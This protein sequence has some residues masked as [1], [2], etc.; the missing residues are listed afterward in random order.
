MGVRLKGKVI[1]KNSWSDKV[2]IQP[3]YFYIIIIILILDGQRVTEKELFSDV[4]PHF[5]DGHKKVNVCSFHQDR[6]TQAAIIHCQLFFPFFTLLKM[7]FVCVP[8]G[9]IA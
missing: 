4:L 3:K 5:C 7:C 9:N 2:K 8:T 1:V 6:K